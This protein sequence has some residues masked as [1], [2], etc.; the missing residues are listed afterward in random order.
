LLAATTLGVMTAPLLRLSVWPNEL[1]NQ[2]NDYES[3]CLPH[4]SELVLL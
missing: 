3:A 4:L 2:R 1:K